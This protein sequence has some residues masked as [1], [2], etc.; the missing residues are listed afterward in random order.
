[1][2]ISNDFEKIAKKSKR[3]TTL[4]NIVLST[5]LALGILVA[6]YMGLNFLTSRNGE[7]IRDRYVLQSQ[8]AYPNIS[9]STWGFNPTSQFTGTFYSDRFKDIDGIIVPFEPFEASYSLRILGGSNNG[10]GTMLGDDNRSNYTRGSGN[11]VPMFYNIKYNYN[12]KDSYVKVTQD[13][14]LTSEMSGQAVEM[15]ITFD[16][17]YTLEEIMK[18]VPDNLKTNWYW[19]GTTS[20]YDTSTIQLS[21][22]F[23]MAY[24]EKATMTYQQAKKWETAA[25][26]AV[27]KDKKADLSKIDTDAPD[28]VDALT[29][30]QNSYTF[31]QESAK[32]ALEKDYIGSTYGGADGNEL[33]SKKDI[34]AYLKA[35][36]DPK[37][38]TFAGVI[39][40][41]RAENFKQLENA[42]WIYASNLGQS[43]QIQPYHK[44]DK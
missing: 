2:K 7:G 37:T 35:N 15:A 40:T 26:E 27:K 30:V 4:R 42:S 43:V 20:K 24:N 18:M 6:T 14:E 22:V 13:I 28:S 1:M 32:E 5:V 36:P 39:L 11:K 38:A 21:D 25:D 12:S 8:I 29:G 9:Y 34:G 16:K 19:I 41:G 3:R 17:S 23:G 10:A 44:L 33:D 31:F